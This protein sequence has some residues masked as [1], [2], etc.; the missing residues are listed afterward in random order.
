MLEFLRRFQWTS[1]A[2]A[3][4]FQPVLRFL[5]GELG[6]PGI[7]RWRVL[8]PQLQDP[9]ED[10][11]W[12]CA[13]IRITVVRRE[14]DP[15]S[16]DG[17]YKVFSTPAHR[18]I[19]RHVVGLTAGRDASADLAEITGPAMG[20]MLL[21][22]TKAKDD[23]GKVPALGFALLPPSNGLAQ[24]TKFTVASQASSEGSPS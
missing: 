2:A 23:R 21:Y 22:P 6:D 1:D 19:A 12:T 11:I 4:L 14:R 9:D 7:R 3:E 8:I 17:R 20:V 5:G 15:R 18:E 24:R 16:N 13:G 10:K